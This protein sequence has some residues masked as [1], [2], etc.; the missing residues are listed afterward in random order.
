MPRDE[1]TIVS[2]GGAKPADPLEGVFTKA[3]KGGKKAAQGVDPND[4]WYIHGKA[5]DLSDF[6]KVHPGASV[7]LVG[8]S[9]QGSWA[10]RPCVL[11]G[12]GL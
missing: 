3:R 1:E 6:V 5:Y 9:G 10:V 8:W 7:C 4:L 2:P 11:T 12:P